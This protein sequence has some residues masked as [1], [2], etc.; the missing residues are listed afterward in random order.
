M[1]ILHIYKDYFPVVGGI[2]NHIRLLAQAQAARG[3]TVTV[4][5]TSQDAR[6]HD[7]QV[8]GVRVILAARKLHVS[9]TP[10]SIELF[11]RVGQ[12]PTDILHLHAPYPV[13]EIAADLFGK[14]RATV[15][16][17]HSDIVRQRVTGAL[18]RPFLNR[19]LAHTARII[20]TSPNYIETSPV[21]A[22]WRDKC[23]VVPLGIELA[24]TVPRHDGDGRRL[25]FVG[26]LRYYKGLDYLLRALVELPNAV[27][28]VVGDGPKETEWKALAESLGVA[29]RVTWRGQVS[30]WERAQAYAEADIFVLPCTERSEA[31]GAVQLEAMSAGLPV[32]SCDVGTGVAWVNE[33]GVTGL[34]VPPKDA[35]ALA[36]AVKQLQ[37]DA[38]LRA[39]MGLAGRAR[40]EERFTVA[41]MTD[42]V[43]GVYA[44][45]LA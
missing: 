25:L 23:T 20:A 34:V 26:H 41:R 6:S 45:V 7:A 32:V 10:L 3:H 16:T 8:N 14:A 19:V 39:R 37:S 13:A 28:T 17:Y 4:L 30:D 44:Q 11:R 31:F 43:M 5:A 27:L 2:E 21:L 40:V 22:R 35:A 18:Y 42:G 38:T 15:L 1:E 12:L 9:S 24:P 29:G 36:S 33:T